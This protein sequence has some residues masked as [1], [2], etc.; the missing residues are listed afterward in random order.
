MV[1]HSRIVYQVQIDVLKSAF[2]E[3]ATFACVHMP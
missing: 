2:D 1:N 3:G